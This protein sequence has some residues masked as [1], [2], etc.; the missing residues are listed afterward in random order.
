MFN[1]IPKKYLLISGLLL[2][3]LLEYLVINNQYI[4]QK[5][6]CFPIF[7]RLILPGFIIGLFF[8][9]NKID[10]IIFSACAYIVYKAFIFLLYLNIGFGPFYMESILFLSTTGET[11]IG[12]IL[13][14][15]L[16][17]LITRNNSPFS[18]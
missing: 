14:Y 15:F 9:D 3:S 13:G 8:I 1:L 7:L 4:H 11:F 12:C 16:K 17:K 18:K 5:T 10:I 6:L 2:F